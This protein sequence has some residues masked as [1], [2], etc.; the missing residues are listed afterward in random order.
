MSICQMGQPSWA[1]M[2]AAPTL[3][4]A[5]EAMT[6]LMREQSMW[7]GPFSGGLWP[8]WS[9]AGCVLRKWNPLAQD[10]DFG[11]HR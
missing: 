8:C 2:N 11:S 3:A 10:L 9:L 4:S 7:I 5:A 6:G 1:F